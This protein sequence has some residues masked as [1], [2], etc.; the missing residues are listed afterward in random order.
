MWVGRLGGGVSARYEGC[1]EVRGQLAG[2]NSVLS[3][4]SSENGALGVGFVIST[5]YGV[6][7][8]KRFARERS[9]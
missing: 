2:A 6:Y 9:M 8:V 1:V 3:H 5:A 7:V 4:G